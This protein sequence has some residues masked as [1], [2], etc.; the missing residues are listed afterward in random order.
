MLTGGAEI[1]FKRYLAFEEKKR[2]VEGVEDS[3][4]AQIRD[5]LEQ[6]A[7]QRLDFAMNP[8]VHA[9]RT[10]MRPQADARELAFDFF[11]DEKIVGIRMPFQEFKTAV[12]AIVIRNGDDIH[13]ARL[14]RA[15]DR[16]RLRIAVA[17]AQK[18][19]LARITRVIGVH[20]QIGA[21]DTFVVAFHSGFNNKTCRTVEPAPR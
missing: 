1:A 4:G 2:V 13:A 15:I 14:R 16:F 19:Q 12:D 6:I 7:P 17:G 20:V 3:L 18:V 8:L 5:R 11:A 21:Q 9:V 10:N